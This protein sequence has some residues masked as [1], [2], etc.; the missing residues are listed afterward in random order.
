MFDMSKETLVV[1][2][3]GTKVL[4][5]GRPGVFTVLEATARITAAGT[6]ISYLL[7]Q[8]IGGTMTKAWVNG[9]EVYTCL[10]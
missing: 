3:P 10:P 9:K 5:M 4:H 8:E 2:G 1:Y 7:I 6:D